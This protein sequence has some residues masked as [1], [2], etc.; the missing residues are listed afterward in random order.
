MP[1]GDGAQT[2]QDGAQ[3]QAAAATAQSQGAPSAE[4]IAQITAQV[5]AAIQPEFDQKI[6]AK[7]AEL[8]GARSTI[9]R[10]REAQ[11]LDQD[12]LK[13]A[14]ALMNDRSAA[15]TDAKAAGVPERFL[16]SAI[17][18]QDV[19]EAISDWTGRPA[20]AAAQAAATP[21]PDAITAAVQKAIAAM[22]I[23]PAAAPA[24]PSTTTMTMTPGTGTPVRAGGETIE[25]L[26]AT[27]YRKLRG[28]ALQAHMAK[29]EGYAGPLIRAGGLRTEPTA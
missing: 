15:I 9:G 7:D 28:P 16:T 20:N 24:K 23:T 12:G 11:G 21:A 2:A 14:V 3:G 18:A 5:R 17:T 26:L 8:H 4:L 22:G 10:L 19:R 1:D 29:L 13:A 6:A 25:E 27:D